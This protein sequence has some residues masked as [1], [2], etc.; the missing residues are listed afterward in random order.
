MP[1]SKSKQQELHV[2]RQVERVLVLLGLSQGEMAEALGVGLGS[3]RNDLEQI[4][5]VTGA[6]DKES[7]TNAER[8]DHVF[9]KVILLHLRVQYEGLQNEEIF[10]G[11]D[12]AAIAETMRALAAY[13]DLEWIDAV[14]HGVSSTVQA[15]IS[16]VDP[17]EYRPYRALLKA[18]YGEKS[19]KLT[20]ERLLEG[21]YWWLKAHDDLELSRDFFPSQLADWAIG[22]YSE[23]FCLSLDAT[24]KVAVDRAL[25]T[26]ESERDRQVLQWR[27]GLLDGKPLELADIGVLLNGVT[28][29]RVRQIEAKALRTLRRP[30][31]ARQLRV[32]VESP[33][34][35]T[36]R[37]IEKTLVLSPAGPI[38]TLQVRADDPVS[39]FLL[40][41]VEELELSVRTYNCLKFGNIG[42]V[43]QLVQMTEAEM[44]KV[45][46]FGRKSLFELRELLAPWNLCF[47]MQ[48]ENGTLKPPVEKVTT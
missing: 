37:S 2:R 24:T 20:K 41:S 13:L 25:E 40:K 23:I 18:L 27:F 16:P 33:F 14:T 30:D 36:R 19:F 7:L 21:L 26:I 6:F 12:P 1:V 42:T 15:M 45:K 46:N 39:R 48:L 8:R 9:H 43:V 44:L 4:G 29:E 10:H 31:C 5:P 17:P 35:Y 3:L 22:H 47:G 11:M 34:S 32:L 28:A 38:T